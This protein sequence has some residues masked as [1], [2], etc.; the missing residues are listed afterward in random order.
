[1]VTLVG[2]VGAAIAKATQT[3]RQTREA[4]EPGA[5]PNASEGSPSPSN[6]DGVNSV[7]YHAREHDLEPAYVADDEQPVPSSP[8]VRYS[9]STTTASVPAEAEVG[10][11]PMEAWRDFSWC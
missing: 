11:S 3:A 10:H 6:P 5:P 1:L 8:P 9:P 2:E 7:D 4:Y